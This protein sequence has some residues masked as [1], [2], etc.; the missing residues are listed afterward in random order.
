MPEKKHRVLRV[1]MTLMSSLDATVVH[2]REVF[3]G[4]AL[5][6]GTAVVFSYSHPEGSTPCSDDLV[7][8]TRMV[9]TGGIMGIA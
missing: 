3:C 1:R 7:L 4:A 8:T 9:N 2:Q 5:A 6:S